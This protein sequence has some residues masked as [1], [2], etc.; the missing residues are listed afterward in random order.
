MRGVYRDMRVGEEQERN[1][2]MENSCQ[3]DSSR[4]MQGNIL[5]ARMRISKNFLR[6]KK[7]KFCRT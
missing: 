6:Q 7:S 3:N 2:K 5:S 1:R 4:E